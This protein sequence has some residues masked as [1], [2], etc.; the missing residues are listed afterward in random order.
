MI[1]I[2]KISEPFIYYCQKVIPLAFDESMSYY[3]CLCNLRYKV[4]EVIDELNSQGLAIDELQEKYFF[5]K[6]N[7]IMVPYLDMIQLDLNERPS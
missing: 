2:N 4:K 5:H 6:K 3:E 1:K 7:G